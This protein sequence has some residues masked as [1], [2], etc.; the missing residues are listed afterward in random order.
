MKG[1]A[2]GNATNKKMLL[3]DGQIALFKEKECN[4]FTEKGVRF[5]LH[6]F[7]LQ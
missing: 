3:L 2:L 1:N 6:D 5:P 7:A 4:Q